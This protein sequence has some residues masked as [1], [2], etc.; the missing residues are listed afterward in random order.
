MY[1]KPHNDEHDHHS[2]TVAHADSW[3]LTVKS[4]CSLCD[5]LLKAAIPSLALVC[6]K[7]VLLS[8]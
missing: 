2:S 7:F 1:Y 4:S 3:K 6:H 8:T 5:S